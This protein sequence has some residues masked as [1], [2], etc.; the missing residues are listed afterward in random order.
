[1]LKKLIFSFTVCCFSL[2]CHAQRVIS[3]VAGNFCNKQPLVL[4]VSDG[5]E[6]FYSLTGADPLSSGFAYDGPVLID[7]TGRVNVRIAVLG[8][9][10]KNSREE[11]EINYNV[12][13][14]NPFNADS[15]EFNFIKKYADAGVYSFEFD[16]SINIPA[17]FDYCFGDGKK[18]VQSGK[19][20]FLDPANCLSRY[21]PCRV[22]SGRNEWR[23]VVF[24]NGSQVGTLARFA[25]PFE[26]T[27]WTQFCFTG[28]KLIWQLDDGDWSA[29]KIPVTLDRSVRHTVKWQSIAY[30]F[31]N[32]VQTFVI[33]AEPSLS[34][35]VSDSKAVTFSIEGDLRY[36]MSVLSAGVSGLSLAGNGL[37]TSATFDTFDGDEISGNA[38]FAFYADGVF[39]GTKEASFSVDKEPPLP[40]LFCT[41][42]GETPLS[43]ARGKVELLLQAE[44]GA[45]IFY[46]VSEPV[47]I[48]ENSTGFSLSADSSRFDSVE[49]GS[50]KPYGGA[51][52]LNSQNGSAVFYKVCAYAADKSGNT[53]R[54][55]EYRVII[56]EDNYYLD[57]SAPFNSE[58][59]GSAQN[60]FTTF[61]QAVDVINSRKFTRFFVKGTFNLA[62]G[63]TVINSNCSFTAQAQAELVFAENSNLLVRNSSF[64]ANGFV[65][66]KTCSSGEQKSKFFNAENS[67]L[68]FNGAEIVGIFGENAIAFDVLN[69]VVEFENSGLTVQAD[70]YACAVSSVDSKILVKNSRFAA[71][72][73]T[74]VDFSVSGGQLE[75][76]NSSCRVNARLGRIAELSGTNARLSGNTYTGEFEKKMRGI[77]PVWSDKN[78]K[79]L[80]DSANTASG[81]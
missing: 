79:I 73:P 43:Y 49:T 76:K 15:E 56:D 38:V 23:F 27:D 24:V 37:F 28:E 46:A 21:V 47:K 53:G 63:E 16:D 71:V 25:V 50:F 36:R 74:A 61:A 17:K 10:D 65:F 44:E 41:E 52:S 1:M 20:L 67:T 2:F 62:E 51:F 55:A 34:A 58:A 9:A 78:T 8:G 3:P 33:P 54:T 13:E 29:S 69:S 80:E 66:K 14:E 31:G 4:D 59:D 35:S 19:E 75:L 68:S 7:S 40:P 12:R 64:E 70:S 32:P 11:I 26:I 18:S 72:A 81:F 22:F 39:Q 57:S 30:E 45:D 77:V 60:P 6:C 42:N 48:K 5:A